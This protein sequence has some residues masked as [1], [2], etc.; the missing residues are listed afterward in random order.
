MKKRELRA[1]IAELEQRVAE[2]ETR[3]KNAERRA[4]KAEN[5]LALVKARIPYITPRWDAPIVKPGDPGYLPYGSDYTIW[6]G[7]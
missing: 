5:E 1:R 3:A 4:E 6:C 2:L 7:S